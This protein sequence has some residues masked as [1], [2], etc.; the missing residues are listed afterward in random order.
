MLNHAAGKGLQVILFTHSL[1][2]FKAMG[3]DESNL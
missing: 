2:S 1:S 3:A